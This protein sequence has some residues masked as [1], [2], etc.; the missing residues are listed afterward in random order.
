MD[1][2]YFSKLYQVKTFTNFKFRILEMIEMKNK[3]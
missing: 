1:S 2:S 3:L